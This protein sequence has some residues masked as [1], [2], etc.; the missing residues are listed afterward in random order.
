M[1]GWEGAKPPRVDTTLAIK[2]G[3]RCDAPVGPALAGLHGCLGAS[4]RHGPVVQG[5]NTGLPEVATNPYRRQVHQNL[6]VKVKKC[7]CGP[8]GSVACQW[9]RLAGQWV[10]QCLRCGGER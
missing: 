2:R 8:A 7:Q 3:K 9:I 5:K 1:S 6:G 10:S 4:R